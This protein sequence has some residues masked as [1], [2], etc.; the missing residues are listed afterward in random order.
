MQNIQ[1]IGIG[2]KITGY[3]QVTSLSS[4]VSC[5]GTGKVLAIQAEA[6]DVRYRPDGVDPTASVGILL[7]AGETHTITLSEEDTSN[8]IRIIE[9]TAGAII[10]VVSFR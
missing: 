2:R 8:Q 10:N 5:P 6:Q 3:H 9:V 7:K 4:A 1:T